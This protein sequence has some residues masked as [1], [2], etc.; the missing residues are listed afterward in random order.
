M[1]ARR[2]GQITSEEFEAKQTYDEYK[3][4]R[5]MLDYVRGSEAQKILRGKRDSVVSLPEPTVR[6]RS[7]I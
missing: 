4:M 1:A 5:L 2:K 7:R 6:R 3:E